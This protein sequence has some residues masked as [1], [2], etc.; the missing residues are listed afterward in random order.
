MSVPDP[1]RT[2][3]VLCYRSYAKLNLYLDVLERRPDDYH[4][5]ETLFQTVSLADTLKVSPASDDLTLICSDAAA[6]PSTEN[7]VYRAA[8]LLREQCG[9]RQGAHMV[10]DK[11]I[12]VAAGL[13]GGSGNAAAALVALNELWELRLTPPELAAL[14]LTL[15]SDVPYCLTGGTVAATGRGE[16]LHPL[17]PLALVWF[18][19]LHPEL[20]VSAGQ[21]YGHPQ[22]IRSPAPSDEAASP[23]FEAAKAALAN[24]QWETV[25]NNAM[26]VPVFSDHP[27]LEQWKNALHREGCRGAL[28]SGS[29][30]TLFGIFDAEADAHR[31]ASRIVGIRTSVLRSINEGVEK[32]RGG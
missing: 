19:L 18:L 6:G 16:N 28:M 3:G 1:E 20:R 13:A 23:R 30:P 12:P 24:R 8:T 2:T 7:L 29:G 32:V 17:K 5:I 9:T 10:L 15:G 14:G 25:L 21:V 31:A 11:H 26:E 27:E 22:L 4:D